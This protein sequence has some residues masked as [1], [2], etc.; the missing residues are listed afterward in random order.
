VKEKIED[1]HYVIEKQAYQQ[2]EMIQE[3]SLYNHLSNIRRE[4]EEKWRMKSRQTW[5]K[6]GDKNTAFF[7]KQATV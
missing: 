2:A 6:S 7:H 1:L 4:E 5:L 3:E